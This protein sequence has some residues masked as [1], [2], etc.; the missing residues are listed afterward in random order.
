MRR[1]V[2]TNKFQDAN[3]A[4]T[5]IWS[6]EEF[7]AHLPYTLEE[8]LAQ[9]GERAAEALKARAASIE[10]A[11]APASAADIKGQ[12]VVITGWA[13]DGYEG[14]QAAFKRF[15]RGFGAEVAEQ[16]AEGVT[17]V[18]VRGDRPSEE[19]LEDAE[20]WGIPVVDAAAFWAMLRG[21]GV[22]A[23]PSSSG[24]APKRRRRKK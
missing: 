23:A 9:A 20:W 24:R 19:K 22:A 17:R 16:V 13:P 21:D 11:P 1:G 5:P 14:D 7:L 10:T 8:C 18:V 3:R 15:V 4:G 2:G 6:P 12:V